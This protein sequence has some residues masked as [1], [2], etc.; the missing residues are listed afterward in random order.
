MI[1]LGLGS[2]L[3]VS[4]EGPYVLPQ[5]TEG[6][7]PAVPL[8]IE[9][10]DP[11]GSEIRACAV[12][13][14]HRSSMFLCE[15]PT[16]GAA[17]FLPDPPQEAVTQGEAA[18][19]DEVDKKAVGLQVMHDMPAVIARILGP[20]DVGSG[21]I[22]MQIGQ[23]ACAPWRDEQQGRTPGHAWGFDHLPAV[24]QTMVFEELDTELSGS[25]A[26]NEELLDLE[27]GEVAV[28]V[29]GL[30]NA[31][32]VASTTSSESAGLSSPVSAALAFGAA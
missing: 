23:E 5:P 12:W 26:G 3:E 29:E 28:V 27:S 14:S 9:A 21:E 2:V 10:D 25:S 30:E 19:P 31:A 18:G 16:I 6:S 13:R 1:A 7:R 11:T 20:P 32:P 17:G 8:Q 22:T 15:E 4:D 24:D